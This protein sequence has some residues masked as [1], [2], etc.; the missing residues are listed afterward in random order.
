MKFYTKLIIYLK[1]FGQ[2]NS[3]QTTHKIIYVKQVPSRIVALVN[4]PNITIKTRFLFFMMKCHSNN[5]LKKNNK[6]KRQKS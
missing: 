5:N 1:L 2:P 4:S 6:E 3:K